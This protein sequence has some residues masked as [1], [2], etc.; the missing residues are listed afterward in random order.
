VTPDDENRV[1]ALVHH[2]NVIL[3]S[4]GAQN[5]G[6]ENDLADVKRA[7]RRAERILSGDASDEERESVGELVHPQVR[8][9]YG[10]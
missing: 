9:L 2:A 4:D 3:M 6:R 8:T 7:L 10:L 5:A 1:A